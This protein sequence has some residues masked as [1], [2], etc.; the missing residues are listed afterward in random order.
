MRMCETHDLRIGAGS[1]GTDFVD[2]IRMLASG[3]KSELV[4]EGLRVL[5]E[6]RIL[7]GCATMVSP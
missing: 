7:K 3:E 2:H 1:V 6:A 5:P 4:D